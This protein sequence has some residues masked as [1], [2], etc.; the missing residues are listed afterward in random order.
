MKNEIKETKYKGY[1]VTSN[2]QFLSTKIP[3]AHGKE[4]GV[5][6][7]RKLKLDR[8]GY[9]I[10]TISIVENGIHKLKYVPLHRLVYETF[11]GPLDQTM[12]IDHIDNNPLNNEIN[13]LQ[14]ISVS[15]NSVKR[16]KRYHYGNQHLYV[17]D[18]LN[19]K[20]CSLMTRRQISDEYGIS[21]KAVKN[22]VIKNRT[23]K[24]YKLQG[25]NLIIK[26]VEDI[27]RIFDIE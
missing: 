15:E 1:Y 23:S 22:I 10:A 6:R 17:V 8:Y 16:D 19:T 9:L 14:Q 12:C 11:K 26:C 27:E 4:D 21:M 24:F 25:L 13:N 20:T 5:F 7:F 18:D 3:G 2:G